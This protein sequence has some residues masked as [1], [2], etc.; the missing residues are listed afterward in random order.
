MARRV[1]SGILSSLTT[2][3]FSWAE[4]VPI[5]CLPDWSRNT[6]VWAVGTSSGRGTRAKAY[7]SPMTVPAKIASTGMASHSVQRRIWR[8]RERGGGSWLSGLACLAAREGVIVGA[9]IR[10]PTLP[11]QACQSRFTAPAA[12]RRSA[13]VAAAEQVALGQVVPVAGGAD[14]DHVAGDLVQRAVQVGQ[15]V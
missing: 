15:A 1:C 2:R 14:L 5:S 9:A 8:R 6:I 13:G 3:R 12:R 11:H 4:R 7:T 10:C